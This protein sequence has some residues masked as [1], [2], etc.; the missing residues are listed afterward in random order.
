MGMFFNSSSNIMLQPFCFF[1][2]YRGSIS[3]MS[4]NVQQ[5]NF[6]DDLIEKN[7]TIGLVMHGRTAQ[8]DRELSVSKGEY[9]EVKTL[10]DSLSILLR[11]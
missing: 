6:R 4:V 2:S 3:S 1:F 9:L 7:A 5:D 10:F 11:T 8:N